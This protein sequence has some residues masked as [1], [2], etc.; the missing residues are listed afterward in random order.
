MRKIISLRQALSDPGFLAHALPGESW[1]SWRI[2]LMAAVGEV[3]TDAEREVWRQLTG[4]DHEPGCMVE[5]FEAIVGRRGGKS[6]AMAVLIVYLATLCDWTAELSF[7]RGLA[8]I[9]APSERQAAN[10]LR[11]ALGI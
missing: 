5:V 8:L 11:Y 7:E 10:I 1:A 2:L 6:K 4:R 9:V 3:L